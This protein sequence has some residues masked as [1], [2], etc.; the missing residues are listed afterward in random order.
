MSTPSL[1]I[2]DYYPTQFGTT[3]EHLV[4]Q[5]ISRLRE[6]VEV[7]SGVV[8]YRKS[9]N[10]IGLS[11]DE[12]ITTRN[13]ETTDM[14]RLD[15]KR[16]ISL[17]PYHTTKW[18]DEWDDQLLGNIVKPTS[19][20][21]R[22]QAMAAARRFDQ[23]IIDALGG[24]ALTGED[25]TTSTAFDTN[26]DIAVSV[27]GA[28]TSLNLA[29]LIAAKSK[30]GKNEV[31]GQNMMEGDQLVLVCS[32]SEI[33][34]MLTNVDQVSSADYA[35]VK[36]LVNGEV[37]HFMG[38][39]FVRSELLPQDSNNVRTCYAYVKSGLKLAVSQEFTTHMDVLPQRN[40]TLQIRSKWRV[41]ATR[42]EEKKVV[43]IYCDED[44]SL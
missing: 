23:V 33:D 19:E 2:Q 35:A 11:D 43:R 6:T 1:V 30:F 3:W 16:W 5:K 18:F 20:T 14:T 29:K 13:G 22:S 17:K 8:G 25:G 28:D 7:D 41:G 39:R 27:G 4:Q 32:Q 31:M 21:V 37:D 10:Q 9:Y 44:D 12:E 40:H 24:A 38:F 15:E 34:S 42:M 36:A 26:Q